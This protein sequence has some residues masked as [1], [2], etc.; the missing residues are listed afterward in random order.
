MADAE[1]DVDG[2]GGAGG[3]GCE[4]FGRGVRELV[5][6][7]TVLALPTCPTVPPRKDAPEAELTDW[8]SRVM[9][10]TA[11]ANVSG[12]PQLAVPVGEVDGLPVSISLIGPPDSELA[13][14]DLARSIV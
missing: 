5:G 3:G 8:R 14:I 11:P 1:D 12:L 2:G 7:D 9:Q 4:G 13:L 10:L 6:I